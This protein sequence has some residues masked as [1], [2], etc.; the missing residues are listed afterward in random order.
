MQISVPYLIPC[1]KSGYIR[2]KWKH[3][4]GIH[5]Y[6][7]FKKFRKIIYFCT[8]TVIFKIPL[9]LLLLIFFFT[10]NKQQTKIDRNN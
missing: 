10:L 5:L 4:N 8:K 2:L 1:L 3:K 6:K 7:C 9:L